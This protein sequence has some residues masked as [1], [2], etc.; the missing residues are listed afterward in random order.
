MGRN[1]L[2]RQDG[3]RSNAVLAAAGF[4]FYPLEMAR[5]PF[6]RVF[7]GRIHIGSALTSQKTQTCEAKGT[8]RATHHCGKL[9]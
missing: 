7:P 4:N 5:S 8:S 1:D 6:A 2:K 9:D 3:D